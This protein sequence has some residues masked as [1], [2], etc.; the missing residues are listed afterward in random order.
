MSEINEENSPFMCIEVDS[1]T[2]LSVLADRFDRMFP[3][4]MIRLIIDKKYSPM[5]YLGN[6]HWGY[7]SKPKRNPMFECKI[8][9]H[10]DPKDYLEFDQFSVIDAFGIDVNNL[11][12]IRDIKF[13]NNKHY[14]MI[15]SD[16]FYYFIDQYLFENAHDFVKELSKL[17]ETEIIFDGTNEDDSG[18]MLIKTTT[19]ILG[20][21][22]NDNNSS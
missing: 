5:F 15:F 12:V 10:E 7:K 22:K 4:R 20:D 3:G 17:T 16:G 18:V 1:S 2:G 6:K 19:N 11:K 13:S 8:M 21:N 14:G 9:K